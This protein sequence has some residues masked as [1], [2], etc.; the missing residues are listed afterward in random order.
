MDLLNGA[1]ATAVSMEQREKV[2]VVAL[3][4]RHFI[5]HLAPNR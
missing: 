5:K 2:V 4:T 3:S 1:A